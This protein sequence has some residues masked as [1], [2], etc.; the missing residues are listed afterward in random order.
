MRSYL[1]P[2][3]SCLVPLVVVASVACAADGRDARPGVFTTSS[4][5]QVHTATNPAA[6]FDGYRTF[7]FG[8]PEGAPAGYQMTAR[9]AE[10]QRRLQPLIAAALTQR[11]YVE[12]TGRA[13]FFLKF[14]SGLR[15][16]SIHES[17][18]I[19]GEWLPDDE[20]ADFVEGSLV[21][22][23]FDGTSKAK[24]WHGASR[25]KIDPD[26]IDLPQ[27]TRSVQDLLTAFPA[28]KAAAP[29]AP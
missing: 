23:A 21:I 8:S 10:V 9:S 2:I 27:L 16:V 3:R 25:A 22:D 24:V 1:V 12:A 5:A 29:D 13:D 20:N 7:R 19:A 14:G 4:G 11:G 26:R 6:S 17:S 18:G 15:D 28:V